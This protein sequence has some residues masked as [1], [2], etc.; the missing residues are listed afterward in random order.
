VASEF[1]KGVDFSRFS[2]DV[3]NAVCGNIGDNLSFL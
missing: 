2:S 1:I 3:D